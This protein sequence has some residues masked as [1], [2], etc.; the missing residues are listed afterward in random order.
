MEGQQTKIINTY[1]KVSKF[2]FHYLIFFVALIAGYFLFQNLLSKSLNITIFESNDSLLLQKTKLI[3]EFSKFLKQNIKDNDL[4]IHILQGDLQ[5]EDGFI[6]SVNNLISYKGFIVPKYFYFYSTLP[7]KNMT[8]FSGGTYNTDEL[9][10]FI[11]TFVFT[12]KITVSKPFTRV[13]LPLE[14]SLADDFNLSC[15]FENKISRMTCNYYLNDFLDSFFVYMLSK[16][17]PGLQKIFDA[18]KNNATDKGRFC[19]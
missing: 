15:I 10:N 7:T 4:E 18:I 14:T 12:K 13:Q 5:T 3:A 19:E 9:E 8:Y 16:D 6:K 1:K 17:Y 2:F 11:N